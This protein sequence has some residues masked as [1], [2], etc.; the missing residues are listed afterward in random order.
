MV[1][2]EVHEQIQVIGEK[3]QEMDDLNWHAKQMTQEMRGKA[4][5]QRAKYLKDQKKLKDASLVQMMF[6]QSRDALVLKFISK[7]K[8]AVQNKNDVI[9]QKATEA[10]LRT[11]MKS[12]KFNQ[13]IKRTAVTASTKPKKTRSTITEIKF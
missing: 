3:K 1:N 8:Q 12:I 6:G 7:L 13:Q 5:A 10:F 11:V 4:E 2:S 9:A